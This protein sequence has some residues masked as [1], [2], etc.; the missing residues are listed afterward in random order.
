MLP[1]IIQAASYIEYDHSV[2]PTLLNEDTSVAIRHHL[3]EIFKGLYVICRSL[4]QKYCTETIN[5][6][7]K[8]RCSNYIDNQ[9]G[10]INSILER[11]RRTIV[12][13]R[14]L[15]TDSVIQAQT[16]VTDSDTLHHKVFDRAYHVSIYAKCRSTPK[17]VEI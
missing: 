6:F 8:K 15:I 3:T 2:I 9:K 13:D 10:M 11:S 16:L 17:N 12:L 14:V 7:V 5:T 4:E 1:Q